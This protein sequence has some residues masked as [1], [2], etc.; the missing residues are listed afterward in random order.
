MRHLTGEVDFMALAGGIER[1]I[2]L[3]MPLNMHPW[4][5]GKRWFMLQVL[6]TCPTIFYLLKLRYPMKLRFNLFRKVFWLMDGTA[7]LFAMRHLTL[8]LR[9]W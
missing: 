2:R 3:F 7:S 1:G 6:L 5:H 8:E 9:F 4:R